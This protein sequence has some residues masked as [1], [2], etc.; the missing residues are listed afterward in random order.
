MDILC[1]RHGNTFGPGDKVVWVGRETDLPLVDKGWAQARAFGA[2][3]ARLDLRPD[4]IYCASLRRTRE[5]AAGVI[6]VL[7]TGAPAPLVD[8]RLDEIHYGA[9]AGLTAE[10]IVER[11][12]AAAARLEAWSARDT[13]PTDAGWVTTEPDMRSA[14]EGFVAEVIAPA[15]GTNQRILVVSSNGVL[16]FLPRVL[17]AASPDHPSYVMKTGHAGRIIGDP[18]AFRLDYWNR[19]PEGL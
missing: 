16:R 9:W 17:G 10:E 8:D 18:G 19:A 2:A 4:R 14:I 11:D 7:G 15:G 6:E 12:P 3:L 13:W 1:A 5:F